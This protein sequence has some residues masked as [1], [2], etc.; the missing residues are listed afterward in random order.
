MDIELATS[1]EIELNSTAVQALQ[2]ALTVHKNR[3]FATAHTGP[4]VINASYNDS[5]GLNVASQVLQVTVDGTIIY[6]PCKIV[7]GETP[8]S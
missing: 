6:I 3:S 4:T 1:Q 8:E 2:N 5:I 7:I